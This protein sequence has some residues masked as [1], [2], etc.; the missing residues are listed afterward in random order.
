MRKDLRL[1]DGKIKA[2]VEEELSDVLYYVLALANI[3]N[4][5]LEKLIKNNR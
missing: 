4:I 2:T 3:C 1:K 5:N